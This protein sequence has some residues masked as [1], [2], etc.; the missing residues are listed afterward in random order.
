MKFNANIIYRVFI[1]LFINFMSASEETKGTNSEFMH[2]F[3]I[4]C[5]E[6]RLNSFNKHVPS[7]KISLWYVEE[8]W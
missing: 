6:L 3:Y 4:L 8:D 1:Y 5:T 2:K 7:F